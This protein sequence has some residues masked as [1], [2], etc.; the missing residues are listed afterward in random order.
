MLDLIRNYLLDH[1][2][3]VFLLG[4]FN[5]VSSEPSIASVLEKKGGFVRL[6]LTNE[7]QATH[8]KVADAIDHIFVDPA[9]RVVE[10]QCWTVDTATA[11]KASDHLPVVADVTVR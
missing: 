3:L 8:P 11:Q 10:Y 6:V 5:A 9:D 1:G 2:E 4:D 7:T